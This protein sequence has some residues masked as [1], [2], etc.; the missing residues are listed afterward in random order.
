MK[1]EFWKAKT[2]I[3]KKFIEKQKNRKGKLESQS[4]NWNSRKV[5]VWTEKFK[6]ESWNIK[7]GKLENRKRESLCKKV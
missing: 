5:K 3:E 2:K 6:R 1:V 7:E 4:I